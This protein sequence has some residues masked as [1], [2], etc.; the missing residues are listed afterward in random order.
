MRPEGIGNNGL[1]LDL[2]F[3]AKGTVNNGAKNV[4]QFEKLRASLAADEIMNAER[5]GTALTKNDKAHRAASFLTKE[6]LAAGRVFNIKGGDGAQY[7]L[8]QTKGGFNGKSGIF[9]YM[10]TPSGKV[11]HQRF[12]S[13]EKITGFPNQGGY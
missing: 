9:E 4:A 8:L 1:K 5:I 13:G 6:Q 3:F 10:L 11:S 12:I 2:Q 7:T